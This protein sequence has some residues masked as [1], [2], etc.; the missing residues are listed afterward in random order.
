MSDDVLETEDARTEYSLPKIR[1][2][3]AH[4]Y[5]T[6]TRL[7]SSPPPH[8]L[9]ES[10]GT[11]LYQCQATTLCRGEHFNPQG[12]GHQIIW[13]FLQGIGVLSG[14]QRCVD[15]HLVFLNALGFT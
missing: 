7:S 9:L 14:P 11:K 4:A 1:V 3:L 15:S 8:A 2:K 10:L 13:G 12:V 6:D 5:T